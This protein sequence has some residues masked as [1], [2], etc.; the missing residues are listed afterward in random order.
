MNRDIENK[1][2]DCTACLASGKSFEHQLPSN[3]YGKLKTSTELG[4]EIQI[5]FTRKLNNKKV[6]GDLQTLI[7]VDCKTAK[8]EEVIIFITNN[9][10]FTEY[11]KR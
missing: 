3:H 10:N 5:N 11:R 9:S 6:N 1:V 2:K 4:Q 7:A 8:T